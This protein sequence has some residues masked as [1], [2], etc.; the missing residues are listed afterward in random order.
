MAVTANDVT[1]AINA[2]FPGGV[3]NAALMKL[4]EFASSQAFSLPIASDT[5]L[6]GVK[7]GTGLEIDGDGVLSVSA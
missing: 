5:V 7:V 2:A 6:G 3:Q 1:L 4:V